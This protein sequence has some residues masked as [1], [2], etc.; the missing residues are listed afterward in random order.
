MWP[1]RFVCLY[2]RDAPIR[3]FEDEYLREVELYPSCHYMVCCR[4]D[5]RALPI[6]GLAIVHNGVAEGLHSAHRPPKGFRDDRFP[7]QPRRRK[8]GVD[9]DC[10]IGQETH[11]RLQILGL[12]SGKC[13]HDQIM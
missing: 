12:K 3:C 2:P 11:H 8:V 13:A 4:L 9:D 10:I 7:L 1:I 6:L 5:G